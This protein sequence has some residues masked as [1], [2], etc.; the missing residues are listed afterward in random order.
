MTA[1]AVYAA[2]RDEFSTTSGDANNREG[3]GV[4]TV[5]FNAMPRQSALVS[6][7]PEP[8]ARMGSART[9]E[10]NQRVGYLV[11]TRGERS[12]HAS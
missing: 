5:A 12:R 6:Q 7:R 11:R 1:L 4:Q 3:E 8:L 9:Y 10:Q 2:R